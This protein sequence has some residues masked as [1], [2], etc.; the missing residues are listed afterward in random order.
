LS[1]RTDDNDLVGAASGG[2]TKALRDQK[3]CNL[4]AA[5]FVDSD[6]RG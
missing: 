2:G 1:G 5:L 4:I 6:Y 3:R